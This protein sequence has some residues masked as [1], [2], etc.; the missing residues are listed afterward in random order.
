MSNLK[1]S[2]IAN[3]TGVGNVVIPTGNK[4][5]GVDVG[6]VYAPGMVIQFLTKPLYTATAVAI[7]SSYTTFT[8]IP[9]FN[10]SITPRSATSKIYVMVRWFGEWSAQPAN[11]DSMFGLKRNGVAVGNG[12]G[13]VGAAQGITM[14]ALSYYASDGSSTPET[15]YFDYYDSPGTTAPVTYQVFACS[16]NAN[17]LY[18]NRTVTGGGGAGLEA[19]V[20]TITVWEIAQ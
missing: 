4:L 18:T 10:I 12:I 20:S 2:S 15:M 11:W 6:S 1:V 8:D 14:S 5:V 9:D 13:S 3:R 17:S 7:P 19:G 16:T